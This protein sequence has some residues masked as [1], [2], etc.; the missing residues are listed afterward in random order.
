MRVIVNLHNSAGVMLSR[1]FMIRGGTVLSVGIRSE[2]LIAKGQDFNFGISA[3]LV[4]DLKPGDRLADGREAAS[5]DLG[6]KYHD[7]RE[8]PGEGPLYEILR[9]VIRHGVDKPSHGTGCVCM[10]AFSTEIRR[11]ITAALGVKPITEDDYERETSDDRYARFNA[12]A[13]VRYV[14]EMAVR[15]L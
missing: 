2:Y 10:D 9:R 6:S 15:S 14:L 11:H 5:I 4:P 8:M 1:H 12:E 13:R 3:Q 7:S